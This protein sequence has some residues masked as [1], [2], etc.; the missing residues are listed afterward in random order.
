MSS[1]EESV[2]SFSSETPSEVAFEILYNIRDIE[3]KQLEPTS[4]SSIDSSNS[5]YSS[6][7]SSNSTN[8][9][10]TSK[11]KQSE[12]LIMIWN[13]DFKYMDSYQQA[14]K[15][16]Y[17]NH[18]YEILDAAYSLITFDHHPL[19]HINSDHCCYKVGSVAIGDNYIYKFINSETLEYDI[20]YLLKSHDSSFMTYMRVLKSCNCEA[21]KSF[22]RFTYEQ[23]I[24]NYYSHINLF[25]NKLHYVKT[26]EQF[27]KVINQLKIF[28]SNNNKLI[29]FPLNIN[30]GLYI[31]TKP[32][33]LHVVKLMLIYYRLDDNF[34]LTE[35]DLEDIVNF[36]S[37]N[38]KNKA[39][40]LQLKTRYEKEPKYKVYPNKLSLLRGCNLILLEIILS[41]LKL[42]HNPIIPDEIKIIFQ[43]E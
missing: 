18:P 20:D 5:T 39:S 33:F 24:S 25:I 38:D 16:V 42:T 6:T 22:I 2:L 14:L 30:S 1:S 32:Q 27:M 34:N 36:N 26:V 17:P 11:S 7:K 12:K 19:F 43:N 31:D 41:W 10:N 15:L 35:S 3:Q 23:Q 9:S 21:F 37:F 13:N 4:D 28:I 8:D 40:W 29:K